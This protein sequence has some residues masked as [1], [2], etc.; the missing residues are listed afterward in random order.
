M[1]NIEDL[2]HKQKD[3]ITKING[4]SSPRKKILRTGPTRPWQENL[5]QYQSTPAPPTPLAK[6]NVPTDRALDSTHLADIPLAMREQTVSNAY[7][8]ALADPL[9][10][11]EQTVSNGFFEGSQKGDSV[12]NAY[13]EALADPLA[14]REQT[15]SKPLAKDDFEALVGKERKL[16]LFIFNRCQNLGALETAFITT[17]ELRQFL[18]IS[19]GRL[20]NVIY[21]LSCKGFLE[22]AAVKNGRS[23][24]RKF[25]IKLDLFQK[26]CLQQSVSNE[27]AMREHRVSIASPKAY[28]EALAGGSSSS[29]FLDLK[30]LKTT[31]TEET[32][33]VG[34]NAST[35]NSDWHAIDITPLSSIGFT[36]GHLG[37]IFSLKKLKAVEVQDSIN[38]FQFDLFQNQKGKEINGSPLNFFMGILRKGVPY[39]PPENYESSEEIALRNYIAGKRRLEERRMAEESELR[40][41]EF[42]EWKNSLTLARMEAI[43]PEMVRGMPVAREAS[44]R[45]YFEET[46][47]PVKRTE[48]PGLKHLKQE[49]TQ[50]QN[51]DLIGEVKG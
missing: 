17:E 30:I 41:I 5:P 13:A 49:Q 2:L 36:Q 4:E 48:I 31:T 16:L 43:I 37:Q 10:M 1:A 3:R 46:I 33:T 38:F 24:W 29:S 28:A 20:R 7:A 9:A 18:E 47:W 27:L 32:E 25:Q 22:V 23:G 11:R 26:L 39:A 21:R 19:S 14:M 8:E 42:L 50:R 12:S 6:A 44:L 51:E 15:V 34:I 45:T 35:L 40:G